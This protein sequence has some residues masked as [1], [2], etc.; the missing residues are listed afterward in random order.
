MRDSTFW[1][2]AAVAAIIG[3]FY[4]GHGL[5]QTRPGGQAFLE[6]T[7]HAAGVANED[8]E[9]VFT[10]SQDGKTIFMWQYYGAK[11]P[12]YLGKRDAIEQK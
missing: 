9:N 8:A 6:N 1:R 11:P 4:V 2:A 10:S 5:H 3:L 12:R 7:A